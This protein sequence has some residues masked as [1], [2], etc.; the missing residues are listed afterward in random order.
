MVSDGRLDE[1]AVEIPGPAGVLEGRLRR[2][3]GEPSGG[4]VVAPPHPLYGGTMSNP[5]VVAIVRA[6]AAAGYRTL[7]FNWRGTG[8]SDGRASG[9]IEDA[10]GDYLAALDFLYET[11]G[12]AETTTGREAPALAAGYSFGAMTALTVS[13][14]CTKIGGLLLV[15]PPVGLA[16]REVFRRIRLPAAIVVGD[17]DEFAPLADVEHVFGGRPG[18]RLHVVGGADHFFSAVPGDRL[19]AE[20]S[21]ALPPAQGARG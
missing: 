8:R 17:S 14:D 6:L 11:A 20:F 18:T 13:A 5:V 3:N 12:G 15:A 19:V 7:R 21:A 16:D 10:T 2:V 4:A 9:A 1:E